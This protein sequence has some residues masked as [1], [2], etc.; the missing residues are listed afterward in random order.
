MRSPAIKLIALLCFHCWKWHL[1]CLRALNCVVHKS[2][3]VSYILVL[4]VNNATH[5]ALLIIHFEHVARV[6]GWAILII[7][8]A[9]KHANVF[10]LEGDCRDTV[11]LLT[12]AISSINNILLRSFRHK[13]FNRLVEYYVVLSVYRADFAFWKKL[14]AVLINIL[15]LILARIVRLVNKLASILL[16]ITRGFKAREMLIREVRFVTVDCFRIVAQMLAQAG[17]RL[18]R[19]VI[20]HRGFF[21]V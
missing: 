7:V 11:S 8:L 17:N 3:A 12:F 6:V 13:A 19:N 14:L 2:R 20:H 15:Y 18:S 4:P 16:L 9:L 1:V 10:I 5:R 21:C